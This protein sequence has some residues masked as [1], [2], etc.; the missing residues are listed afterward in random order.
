M[1]KY[2]L[3]FGPILIALLVG[4]FAGDHALERNGWP[5][6]VVLLGLAALAVGLAGR[7]FARFLKS[8]GFPVTTPTVV[9]AAL[10]GLIGLPL[11]VWL[12][13]LCHRCAPSQAMPGAWSHLPAAAIAVFFLGAMFR[14][15]QR[16]RSPEGAL[17]VGGAVVLAAVY[18][19]VLTGFLILLRI[20]FGLPAAIAVILT[21][22]ACDIGAYF[23]GR[24]VGKTKL[25]PWISPGK[26][27][28][29]LAGGVA[30]SALVAVGFQQITLP[31][32]V[33]GGGRILPLC[34]PIAAALFGAA[35]AV[36]GQG[37]DLL[38]SMFK[39]DAGVKDSGNALPGFGGLIDVLD[40]PIA[41]APIAYGVMKILACG[42]T[43][44]ASCGK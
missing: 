16:T 2:R 40:S 20:D 33:L 11:S 8:K 42:A 41:I 44:A 9:L 26:T 35:L 25:I 19:G 17:Q 3:I 13:D 39:R 21:T 5:K 22:K 10:V 7:E 24:A 18:L 1:L 29:G 34:C 30:F 14:H 36:L 6:G 31:A 28:E 38:A 23:T 12:P 15:A 32:S 43:C 27:R 4:V 37:G